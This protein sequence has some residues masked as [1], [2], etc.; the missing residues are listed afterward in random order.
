VQE[1][2]ELKFDAPM[3]SEEPVGT[4]DDLID[5]A[6][7]L[8]HSWQDVN[9]AHKLVHHLNRS[10]PIGMGMH[11]L[12]LAGLLIMICGMCVPAVGGAIVALGLLLFTL[13]YSVARNRSFIHR[14]HW[15]LTQGKLQS[16]RM[17]VLR[18]AKCIILDPNNPHTRG[19]EAC[20]IV[21]EVQGDKCEP[22]KA[23][24]AKTKRVRVK[25]A[26]LRRQHKS[27][28][29]TSS[30]SSLAGTTAQTRGLLVGSDMSAH[31]DASAASNAPASS[32]ASA[33]DILPVPRR[34][35]GHIDHFPGGVFI[36]E[37]EDKLYC[38][39]VDSSRSLSKKG[40]GEFLVL[41][42]LL[43]L[44]NSAWVFMVP[45]FVFSICVVAGACVGFCDL[46]VLV[47]AVLG[48]ACGVKG[49][50][51]PTKLS[52]W[53]IKMRVRANSGNTK[54][55]LLNLACM[56]TQVGDNAQADYCAALAAAVANKEIS[57]HEAQI[58]ALKVIR[59][60]R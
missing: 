19:A 50:L 29:L 8:P 28:E 39:T 3:G 36:V 24:T 4:N 30:T 6:P 60:Q 59:A 32:D 5:S 53:A 47:G 51:V 11:A 16:L 22:L 58:R 9:G 43:F 56:Y 26:P 17:P 33:S 45:L 37:H 41:F 18:R 14:V 49:L 48:S 31:R 20:Q 55:N 12:S 46:G 2:V 34:V 25:A 52:L 10:A 42:F 27:F 1:G 7:L 23:K 15:L 38:G 44:C 54:D 40:S 35:N 21:A 13:G 57:M